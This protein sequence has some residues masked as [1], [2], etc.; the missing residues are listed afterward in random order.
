V[1]IT[2]H[3]SAQ[4]I[5]SGA[6]TSFTVAATGQ[7]TLTY[8]WQK[9][10]ANITNGGHYSG[11]TTTT[12]TVT[13]ASSADV[14][15][16]RCVVTDSNGSL[17]SNEAA[18]TLKAATS[19]TGQPSAQNV[20]T[21]D[22][23][24]FTVTATGDGTL[25]YQWQKNSVNVTNGGHYS[26][27]TTATLAI[28]GA[29]SSDV[30]SYRCVVTGGCGSATSNTAA[31][32]LKAATTITA[33]PSNQS[34]N[35]GETASF[36]VT[37][38]GDGT[39][40]YQ[41]QKDTLNLTDGN[42]ISG[43][44]TNAL[45]ITDVQSG[46]EGA[47]RCVVTGG[48]GT[49]NSN[50]ATL[51]VYSCPAGPVNGNFETWPSGLVAPNWTGA[52]SATVANQFVKST[53]I[54]HGGTYAQGVKARDAAN[55]WAHVYQ[56]F[57]T[58]VG[59][60]LTFITYAYPTAVQTG[61]NPQVGV[62]TSTARPSTWLYT[63]SSF[64]R[65]TWIT[66]GP[67]GYT[68]TGTTTYLFLDVKRVGSVD[69]TTYWDDVLVYRAYLPPAPAVTWASSTSLNVNVDPGC[70]SA[71][72]SAQYAISIGGGAY[73]LGTHYVQANGTVGT[74][75]VWQTDATWGTKTVTGL[76]TGTTYTFQIKARYDGTYTQAT[77]LGAGANG[78]P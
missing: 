37:A 66:I 46:D 20:C 64:T 13:G 58:N 18:L 26:G 5:C 1:A 39:L 28:T 70:N 53:A 67:L 49:V 42:G 38:T 65:N 50:N 43:A 31:L 14:A 47:Y 10:Q 27:C 60:A 25:T 22:N 48:C 40:T 35:S 33:Q 63:L 4:N 55:A 9:A 75:A 32:T 69:T 56:G 78:T 76:S 7:G 41:W 62:N 19:I 21:G 34:L 61:V 2:Q 36:S 77:N 16:Y 29:D 54:V 23:A 68:A 73:T 30:T 57:E 3:P 74:T 6:N 8:Q 17:N 71:N 44:T 12:L 51:T 72:S 11:C 52:Y 15:N 59:D 24:S 45:Q